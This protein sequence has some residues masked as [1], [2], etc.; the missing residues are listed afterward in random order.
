MTACLT[1]QVSLQSVLLLPARSSKDEPKWDMVDIRAVRRLKR[2]V[3]LEELKAHAD[4]AL[5]GMFLLR[6][7]RLS[8]QPVS[9]AHWDFILHLSEEEAKV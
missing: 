6:I 9:K 2:D 1:L 5:E 7:P 8:V 4:G 3:T